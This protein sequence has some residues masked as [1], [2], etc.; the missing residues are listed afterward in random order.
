MPHIRVHEKALAHLS[1]GLYRS[2]ASWLRELVSNAWD[3]NATR[4]LIS[5]NYPQFTQIAVQDN[6]R[7][8]TKSDFERLME[9][10]IGNSEKRSVHENLI[11]NRPVIGR[12][13][14][15]LLGIAQICGSFAVSSAREGGEP[16]RARVQLYDLIRERL[17]VNDPS[18]T[19]GPGADETLLSEW[20]ARPA[21]IREVDWRVSVFGGRTRWPHP[22]NAN[23][24]GRC[25]S[26]FCT[27]FSRLQVDPQVRGAI[28]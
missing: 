6:G 2:P 26:D 4:V 17:D 7:G 27:V 18:V 22:R 19:R 16:F 12:L 13:G 5:T 23:Y 14:I 24:V 21:G 8:F 10:G 25:S 20:E 3:A 28:S 1:C 15:G 9:G 11:H